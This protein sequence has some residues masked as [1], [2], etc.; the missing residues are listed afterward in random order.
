MLSGPP[1]PPWSVQGKC[2]WW[3]GG[4]PERLSCTAKRNRGG[5]IIHQRGGVGGGR[6]RQ[7]QLC[8]ESEPPLQTGQRAA[9]EGGGFSLG[10]GSR[11][12]KQCGGLGGRTAPPLPSPIL[13][14]PPPPLPGVWPGLLL[15][16]IQALSIEKH[17]RGG[18]GGGFLAEIS[19]PALVCA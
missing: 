14:P 8:Q 11:V 5:T 7:S 1:P 3:G 18:Q 13:P 2:W 19:L 17:L 4:A 16:L 15:P 10:W 12:N 9:P 6:R